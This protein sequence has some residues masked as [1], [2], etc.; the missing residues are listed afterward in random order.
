MTGDLTINKAS[1]SLVLNK[2]VSGQQNIIWGKQGGVERW[3]L[4]FGDTTPEGS[5]NIGSN[6]N[7]L[8]YNDA[9]GF[10]GTVLTGVRSTGL[11]QVSADPTNNLGIATKQYV[12]AGDVVATPAEYISA[13]APTK[14]I[15]C[16]SVWGAAPRLIIAA[17][18]AIT[19]DFS[20]AFDFDFGL[21]QVHTINNPINPK[22]GQ[23]GLIMLRQDATGGRTISGW[24][25]WYLFPGGVK[26]TLS[27]APNSRDV[28]SYVFVGGV[29]MYCTFNAG[30]A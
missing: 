17:P 21:S 11:L 30:F 12:D 4:C 26:P 25:S 20:T 27:T 3:A 23:K 8:N 22:D 15:N 10:I 1:P 6:F 19:P 29:G 2:S 13:S 28:I 9:G 7:L 24:G 14:K 18:A 16:N 5:G